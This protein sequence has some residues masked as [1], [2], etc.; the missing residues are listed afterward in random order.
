[1]LL[2]VFIVFVFSWQQC[3][4][5]ELWQALEAVQLKT[6]VME[7][8]EGLETRL[9]DGGLNLSVGQRQLLCL[10]RA[11][12]RRTRLLLMDEATANVDLETDAIIQ[13]T[14]RKQ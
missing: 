10:A 5:A 9:V 6:A 13:S 8:P 7:M 11:I 2:L 3:T 4:D 14:L 1:M 12:T